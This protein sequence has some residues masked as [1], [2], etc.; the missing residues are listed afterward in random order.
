M[1]YLSPANEI[2]AYRLWSVYGLDTHE[3]AVRLGRRDLEPAVYNSLAR[4]REMTRS[5]IN[6][7]LRVVA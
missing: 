3:I 5:Q 6:R 2:Q 1:P 7:V 4:M